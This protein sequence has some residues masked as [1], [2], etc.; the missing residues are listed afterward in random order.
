MSRDDDRSGDAARVNRTAQRVFDIVELLADEPRGLTISE[1]SARLGFALSSTHSLVHAMLQR[2]YV[3]A[4]DARRRRFRLGVRFMQLGLG[5]LEGI[6]LREAA[7]APLERV[8]AL[9]HDSAFLAVPDGG[10]LAY[11]DKVVSDRRVIRTDQRLGGHS[12]IHCSSLGKAL[13][14]AVDDETVVTIVERVGMPQ[15]TEFS[16]VD[17]ATLLDNLAR[18]RRRGYSIDEQES[19]LG[20][21]CVAAPVRDHKGQAIA[22]VSLSTVRE[23]FEPET[24]GPAIRDAALEISRALGW[25][26]D[27]DSLYQPVDGSLQLILGSEPRRPQLAKTAR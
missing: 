2:G 27:P 11:V 26:E 9:T 12:P 1:I 7:R 3:H 10:E 4:D 17:V 14:A 13:L 6:D 22:A 16:V 8:V 19:S 21:C 25:T 24:A 23:F 15:M 5:V 18:T 20:V